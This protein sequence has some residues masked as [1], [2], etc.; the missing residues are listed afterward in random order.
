MKQGMF[1][2]QL[3]ADELEISLNTLLLQGREINEVVRV[4]KFVDDRAWLI[5]VYTESPSRQLMDLIRADLDY[6]NGSQYG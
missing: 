3:S 4:S 1:K 5:V 6:L 2:S